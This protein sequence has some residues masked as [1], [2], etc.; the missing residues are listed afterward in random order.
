MQATGVEVI[1]LGHNRKAE[2]VANCAVQEDAHAIAITSYQGGHLEYF[3]Y[4]FDLLHDK[5]AGHIKIFGGGGGTIL[6]QEIGELED[7]G[8]TRIYTPDDGRQLGLQGMVNT[9]IAQC[10][11]DITKFKSDAVKKLS[12]AYQLAIAR[13]ITLAENDLEEYH[14]QW[15]KLAKKAKK[16]RSPVLGITGTGGAGKSSIIDELIWRFLKDFKDKTAAIISVDPSRKKTG[17]ALLGDRI[18]MNAIDTPRV[19]MRSMAT[20]ASNVSLSKHIAEAIDIVQAAGFDLVILETSGI[21]QSDVA[22][23]EHADLAIYVMTPE[24]GAAT[25]LEKIDMLDFAD[26]VLINKFDK[27]GAKDALKAVGKQFQRNHGRWEEDVQNM[28]VFGAVA[29]HFND[30]GMNRFYDYLIRQI[31]KKSS[32][33]WTLPES[34]HVEFQHKFEIIPPQRIRYLAEISQAVREYNKETREERDIAEQLYALDKTCILLDDKREDPALREKLNDLY[35]QLQSTLKPETLS[36]IDQWPQ[37]WQKYQQHDFHFKVRDEEITLPEYS[38]TLSHL[39]IPKVVLPPY[40][41]WGDIVQWSQQENVPGEFPFTAGV[42]P[43]KRE[44]EDPTRMFAG[45]GAPERTNERFHYLSK[46]QQFV[47]LSTAFDSVTLY[48]E[49]PDRRPDIY[50]KVGNSGVS[51][52]CLDDAKK[53]YSGFNLTDPSTSVSMTINGPAPTM[54][55]FFMNAAIDQQCELFIRED[56]MEDQVEQKL[57]EKFDDH[58]LPRPTYNGEKPS[59]NNGLGLMLLGLTGDE[60]LPAETYQQIKAETLS[61]VRGTIQA[62]I[63]KEDQAQNTCIFSTEFS[64][65]MMGDVQQYFVDTCHAQ[66]LFR[67]HLGLPYR[68]SRR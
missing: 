44:S 53:L 30:P 61:S 22:I 56:G 19:Y 41:N 16:S 15:D 55:A 42:F 13:W 24:Y 57:K 66:F 11:Y 18:R 29:S 28:P 52:C 59:E 62:D 63:L 54:C 51:I 4:L 8:I 23:A 46:N 50:G 47:R 34:A 45:Q 3:K 1:H 67:I 9:L 2:E 25:Q 31:H 35:E 32:A 5:G 43:F 7:Y 37:K 38:E 49:D 48:G 36:I 10:D 12:T 64:L 40:K 6:A 26:M 27:P 20:R 17:G 65:R 33:N 58:N 68:R 39:K 21:G 14:V 60:V